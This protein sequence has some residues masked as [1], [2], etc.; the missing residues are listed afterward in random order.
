[1]KT[2]AQIRG[3]FLVLLLPLLVLGCDGDT[4]SA[5]GGIP[6]DSVLSDAV[7]TW[8]LSTDLPAG[9]KRVFVTSGKQNGDLGGPSGADARC[10]QAASAAGLGGSWVAWVSTKTEH[11]IDRLKDV[12]PWHGLDGKRFFADK[13][14]IADM[15]KGPEHGLW[16]DEKGTFL[17]TDRIW[18]GTGPDGR[19]AAS[20]G[21]ACQ[22]WTS[23]SMSDQAR[24]GTVGRTDSHWTSYSFT[25][26]DQSQQ[27][28]ICFEQ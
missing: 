1:M 9:A 18:T 27:R 6:S 14:A 17:P 26:C 25:S 8:D 2:R 10:Q 7:K 11:A 5:D 4:T 24:I 13:A 22:G 23:A 20:I 28:L 19:Y 12:G 15:F 16:R 21:D 3:S